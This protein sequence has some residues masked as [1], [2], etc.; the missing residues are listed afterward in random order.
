MKKPLFKQRYKTY[1]F[2]SRP[3]FFKTSFFY[4]LLFCALTGC[5][6]ESSTSKNSILPNITSEGLLMNKLCDIPE[7]LPEFSAYIY[8]H[9]GAEMSDAALKKLLPDFTVIKDA[10]T[11]DA[12]YSKTEEIRFVGLSKKCRAAD[13]VE[14]EWRIAITLKQ[15][16]EPIF[17]QI[18]LLHTFADIYEG[19]RKFSFN[20]FYG[21]GEE[22]S[23]L[24][25]KEAVGKSR[26]EIA[27]YIKNLGVRLVKSNEFSEEYSHDVDM[28]SDMASRLAVYDFSKKITVNYDSTQRVT[29]INVSF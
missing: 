27:S 24:V 10:P 25:T 7:N 15:N 29:E 1:D 22:M 12:L 2:F 18:Y 21:S 6:L 4:A 8:K 5:D 20:H 19:K 11:K 16:G 28:R 14:Y 9:Y 26:D 23:K 3:I 13:G 17:H